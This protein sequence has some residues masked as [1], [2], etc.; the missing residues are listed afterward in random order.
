MKLKIKFP[1]ITA[2]LL[3]LFAD[4][5]KPKD[6][7]SSYLKGKIDG[8]AFEC[9]ANISANKPE[10][11][12]GSG[13]G[14]DPTIR[15]SGDWMTHSIKLIITSEGTS[16]HSANYIFEAGKW[17]SASLVWSSSETYYAGD[18]CVI[19]GL[20]CMAVEILLFLKSAKTT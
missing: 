5:S 2:I 15:I 16:I 19:C 4:C 10:P 13:G 9:T 3:L 8:A 17:R 11:I 12:P 18:G 20:K 6:F 7:S 14:D 1:V